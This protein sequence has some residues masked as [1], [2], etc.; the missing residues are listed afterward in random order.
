[1]NQP[2]KV[3]FQEIDIESKSDMCILWKRNRFN[4]E[5]WKK[6]KEEQE[7]QFKNFLWQGAIKPWNLQTKRLWIYVNKPENKLKYVFEIN[8]T[9]RPGELPV[10]PN[11]RSEECC[12]ENRKFNQG[13]YKAEGGKIYE[14]AYQLTLINE[15]TKGNSLAELQKYEHEDPEKG[16]LF[17]SNRKPTFYIDSYPKLKLDIVTGKIS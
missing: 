3:N 17:K 15:F 1:M 10:N 16:Y 4:Y 11:C 5:E 2:K 7:C 13:K 9:F 8:K 12:G 14:Y 6:Q